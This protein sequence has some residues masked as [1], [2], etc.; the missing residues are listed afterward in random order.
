MGLSSCET[1]PRPS[2][3]TAAARRSVE[4]LPAMEK[5]ASS[6]ESSTGV[7]KALETATGAL[8]EAVLRAA[9]EPSRSAL[10]GQEAYGRPAGAQQLECAGAKFFLKLQKGDLARFTV[11]STTA[12]SLRASAAEYQKWAAPLTI[13]TGGADLA[14]ARELKLS[15]PR[16]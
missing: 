11:E 9:E 4:A 15:S 3:T 2:D 1:L 12:S 13:V 10:Q 14:D 6:V 8:W 16:G 7:V 5:K